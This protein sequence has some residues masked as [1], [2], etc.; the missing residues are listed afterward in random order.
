MSSVTSL[1]AHVFVT[2]YLLFVTG[3][4]AQKVSLTFVDNKLTIIQQASPPVLFECRAHLFGGSEAVNSVRKS[5]YSTIVCFSANTLNPRDLNQVILTKVRCHHLFRHTCDAQENSCVSCILI[6]NLVRLFCQQFVFTTKIQCSFVSGSKKRYVWTNI[7][8]VIF[9]YCWCFMLDN[10]NADYYR[11][12]ACFEK[13]LNS[14]V[15]T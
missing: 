4:V 14:C 12:P 9:L 7:L 3:C 13:R 1:G 5:W 6:L 11:S 8:K 15:K 10:I 2:T